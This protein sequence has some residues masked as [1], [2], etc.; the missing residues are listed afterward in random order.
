MS[1]EHPEKPISEKQLEANRRNAKKSTGP[2]TIEGKRRS[3]LNAFRHGLTGQVSVM[4]DEDR[5]AHDKFFNAYLA[6]LNPEG[7]VESDLAQSAAEDAWRLKR[8]RAIEDNIFALGHPDITDTAC[9]HGSHPE[10]VTA[11]A[12]ARTFVAD[13]RKFQL[14]T[15]YEQRL[16]RS[17]QKSLGLLRELQAERKAAR[18][19]ALGEAQ[20]LAMGNYMKGLPY[21]PA[22]DFPTENGFVFSSAEINLSIERDLRVQESRYYAQCRWKKGDPYLPVP[23]KLI[24]LAKAA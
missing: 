4:T 16:H 13:P 20:M 8:A 24:E 11:L 10:L 7:A 3:S 23:I 22:R 5:A 21:D 6:D 19:K 2:A 1:P 9:D 15:L 14:I 12:A 18:H 17:M